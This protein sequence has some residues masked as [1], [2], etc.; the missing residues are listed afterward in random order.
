MQE[1]NFPGLTIFLSLSMKHRVDKEE[2]HILFK[3]CINPEVC[4]EALDG[5]QTGKDISNYLVGMTLEL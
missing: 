2:A 1:S 4:Q 5:K 3:S